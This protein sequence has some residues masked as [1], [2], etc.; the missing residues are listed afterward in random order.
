MKMR[1]GRSRGAKA[2]IKFFMQIRC[3]TCSACIFMKIAWL[4]QDR[5]E[6]SNKFMKMRLILKTLQGDNKEPNMNIQHFSISVRTVL[7]SS[8]TASTVNAMDQNELAHGLGLLR[9]G[10][11]DSHSPL[12]GVHPYVT[13]RTHLPP[14]PACS[15]VA[16]STHM[17]SSLPCF[18]PK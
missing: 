18:A 10:Q 4:N 8:D 3:H 13:V 17:P 5:E 1:W 7:F 14:F 9:T 16:A 11:H 12:Q 15:C 6:P 2:I